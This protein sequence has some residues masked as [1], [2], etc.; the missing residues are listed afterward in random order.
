MGV[1]EI[2]YIPGVGIS[3]LP[4]PK[5]PLYKFIGWKCDGQFISKIPTTFDKDIEL[6]AVYEK[7]CQKS[8]NEILISTLSLA[9]LAVLVL[10]KK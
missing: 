5:K 10:R 7:G 9:S 1:E 3:N 4:I 8:H 6:I 2:T